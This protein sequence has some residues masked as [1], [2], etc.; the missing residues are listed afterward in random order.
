MDS[1][2]I[3]SVAGYFTS[4]YHKSLGILFDVGIIINDALLA[5]ILCISCGSIDHLNALPLYLRQR[6][7][8]NQPPI[9]CIVPIELKQKVIDYLKSAV[10]LDN[11][12]HKPFEEQLGI[13]LVEIND[14]QEY[15]YGPYRITAYRL[16][17]SKI[18]YGYTVEHETRVHNSSDSIKTM[19][20]AGV[21]K[22]HQK[23]I[24]GYTG[25][26]TPENLSS[27]LKFTKAEM[28]LVTCSDH[29]SFESVLA[30]RHALK[31]SCIIVTR[32]DLG[33]NFEYFNQRIIETD[34]RFTVY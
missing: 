26:I 11:D 12:L 25:L 10:A 34:L 14:E 23:C 2:S 17:N 33:V 24:F 15:V 31:G 27:N 28:L 3:S 22:R 29:L 13:N 30:L 20:I 5:K 16:A 4:V 32:Q 7:L 1:L 9:T 19:G 21:Y 6:Q 8:Y 18:N